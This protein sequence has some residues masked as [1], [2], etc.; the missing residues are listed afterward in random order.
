MWQIMPPPAVQ[1]HGIF[2]NPS[3]ATGQ[4]VKLVVSHEC[5]VKSVVSVGK[6]IDICGEDMFVA[7]L[8]EVS[9]DVRQRVLGS[10]I[11]P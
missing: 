8:A 2:F 7:W 11:R 3:S 6:A 10:R 4:R 9:R 1:V 5:F